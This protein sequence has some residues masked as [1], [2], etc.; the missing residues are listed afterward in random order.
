MQHFAG[1]KN[2]QHY[3]RWIAIVSGTN[4]HDHFDNKYLMDNLLLKLH[5]ALNEYFC[6]KA[7]E[8]TGVQ[9]PNIQL[10]K[11]NKFLIVERFNY[12][13]QN[14]SFLGFEEVLT[15]TTPS[16]IIKFS[17]IKALAFLFNRSITKKIV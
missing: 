6:L 4:C 7:I 15:F 10:S 3:R 2:S 17:S 16:S 5:F 1:I 9:I 14:D 8:K 12:E 13:K 11:N